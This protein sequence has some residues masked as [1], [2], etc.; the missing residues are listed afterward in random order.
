MAISRRQLLAAAGVVSLGATPFLRSV[1]AGI[2]RRPA[3]RS[4]PVLT[5]VVTPQF[6]NCLFT[7]T[8]SNCEGGKAFAHTDTLELYGS[9]PFAGRCYWNVQVHDKKQNFNWG[10]GPVSYSTL[11]NTL[12][13]PVTITHPTG[14]A[15]G[16]PGDLTITVTANSVNLNCICI[17]YL[18]NGTAYPV[19]YA[20]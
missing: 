7:L 14:T 13:V 3:P 18:G 12:Y 6:P 2:C 8:S 11:G 19:A 9:F 1:T 17:A 20:R 10:T 16:S 5:N 4:G 15:A